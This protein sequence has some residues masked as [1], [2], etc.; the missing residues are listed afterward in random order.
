MDGQ[1]PNNTSN[2]EEAS[3]FLMAMSQLNQ[4]HPPD[5]VARPSYQA[6]PPNS[7]VPPMP[8]T[9]EMTTPPTSPGV[10]A[11]MPQ[12][13]VTLPTF[14]THFQAQIAA[15]LAMPDAERREKNLVLTR[16]KVNELDRLRHQR[17]GLIKMR[18]SFRPEA[19]AKHYADLQVAG[20]VTHAIYI[21]HFCLT[22]RINDLP[23]E[24]LMKIFRLV[25]SPLDITG[26]IRVTHVCRLW[27]SVAIADR[28]LWNTVCFLVP[29]HF[30]RSFA[31]MERAGPTGLDIHM[32]DTKTNPWS[33]ET[34]TQLIDRMFKKLPSIRK[35]DIF[36]YSREAVLTVLEGLQRV[37]QE[38]LT[39]ELEHFEI[40]KYF[41]PGTS[42][43]YLPTL[44][45]FGGSILPSL[46][47]LRLDGVNIQWDVD[48]L[49]RLTTLDLRRLAMELSPS[50]AVFRAVLSG[51]TGLETL[52]LEAAGPQYESSTPLLPPIPIPSLRILVLGGLSDAYADYILSHFTAPN[53]LDFTI[54][55]PMDNVYP[56]LISALTT[57]RMSKVKILNLVQIPLGGTTIPVESKTLLG[58]WLESMPEMTF[59]RVMQTSGEIFDVLRLNPPVVRG[60]QRV[61]RTQESAQRR[62]I[63]PEL[64]YV[65]VRNEWTDI[66]QLVNYIAFRRGLGYPLKMV[67]LTSGTVARLSPEQKLKLQQALGEFG[68]VQIGGERTAEEDALCKEV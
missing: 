5:R 67:W 8:Q 7:P 62:P 3:S 68:V 43:E 11:L 36:L 58:K 25:V 23:M 20:R 31:L 34:I 2:R 16:A 33:K 51:A 18:P 35:L 38:N 6:I 52:I 44:P 22:F 61:K 30:E 4:Q 13:S 45:L 54:M 14:E 64:V 56:R 42:K 47:H 17:D 57:S 26:T 55:Y 21:V 12:G 48:L 1:P 40:H 10:T 46:R 28:N 39:M 29:K 15:L 50:S 9:P 65:D 53:V 32:G 49:S 60:A 19:F 41:A 59:L 24:L 66:D 37:A 27:R 63:G